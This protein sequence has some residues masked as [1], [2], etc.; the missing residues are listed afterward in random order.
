MSANNLN[1]VTVTGNLAQEP[2]LL[3]LPA[4]Q[5]ACELR[6]ACSRRWQHKLTG[7]WDEWTDFFDARIVG[8]LAPTAHRRLRS[9]HGVAIDG[10][11]STQPCRCDDPTHRS[12]ILILVDEIQFL[13]RTAGAQPATLGP[14]APHPEALRPEDVPITPPA[15][16]QS[17][18]LLEH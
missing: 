5:C 15:S 11:L 12:E 10:R 14:V 18:P 7:V 3:D 2:L 17:M 13:T 1:R 8:G 4:G 6:I 16:A 9:G